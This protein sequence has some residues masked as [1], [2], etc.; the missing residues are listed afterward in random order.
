MVVP[1]SLGNV[2]AYEIDDEQSERQ[3]KE[4]LVQF[5][6][7]VS[8]FRDDDKKVRNIEARGRVVRKTLSKHEISAVELFHLALEKA[9]NMEQVVEPEMVG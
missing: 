5:V 7:C 9:R 4:S 8:R 2:G 6:K 3:A 1:A